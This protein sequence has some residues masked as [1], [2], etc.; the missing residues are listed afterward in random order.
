M[1]PTLM[2]GKWL[3]K[4]PEH[5]AAREEWTSER[6]WEKARWDS[7]H[8]NIHPTDIVFDI[9]AE[10]MDLTGLIAS[11]LSPPGGIVAFEP[12]PKVWSNG[13]AIW[14]ANELSPPLACFA[15]F[16]DDVTDNAGRKL[17][18]RNTLKDWPPSA[19]GPIDSAHGFARPEERPDL[20]HITL[21]DF[22]YGLQLFPNIITMDV[23]GSEL[24]VCRGAEKVL[25]DYH[26]LV[27]VSVHPNFMLDTYGTDVSEF[28][29]FM[30]GLGYEF[31]HLATDHEIHELHYHASGRRPVE[32]P[33]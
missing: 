1:I 16:A 10:E 9:G 24:R 19:Y 20:P 27:Y 23:E 29:D 11:W 18:S 7:V 4:L 12:N 31:I 22:C 8:A 21:D 14:S 13:Y 15:G 3:L 25:R 26:P 2:N 30:A 33:A 17:L 5:R 32:L 28:Y 6:G